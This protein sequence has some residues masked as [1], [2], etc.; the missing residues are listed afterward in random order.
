MME[1]PRERPNQTMERTATG[2]TLAFFP[3][4]MSPLRATRALGGRR[5]SSFR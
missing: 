3:T 2:R 1:L 4:T 5:S